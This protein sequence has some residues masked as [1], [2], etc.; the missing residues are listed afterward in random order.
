MQG[1]SGRLSVPRNSKSSPRIRRCRRKTLKTQNRTADSSV[2]RGAITPARRWIEAAAPYGDHV[3]AAARANPS[4]V[5]FEYA[6]APRV[7]GVA[8]HAGLVP[9][10]I[11]DVNRAF[12]RRAAARGGFF[13]ATFAVRRAGVSNDAPVFPP[14]ATNAIFLGSDG[15]FDGASFADDADA[16]G[17]W[18]HVGGAGAGVAPVAIRG[19]EFRPGGGF[20]GGGGSASSLV[21]R[22]EDVRGE[23]ARVEKDSGAREGAFADERGGRDAKGVEERSRIVAAH[24]VSSALV[25]AEPP[26]TPRLPLQRSSEARTVTVQHSTAALPWQGR[27]RMF[28]GVVQSPWRRPVL[29]KWRLRSDGARST[30]YSGQRVT[31]AD[32]Q[33]QPQPATHTT[34]ARSAVRAKR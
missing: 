17:A 11:V 30:I 24:F 18:W 27:I 10:R 28:P 29:V 20:G 19:A 14:D 12:E 23:S 31:E 25:V 32:P 22:F 6:P 26:A 16:G 33:R 5:E 8:L 1:P 15:D 3:S 21:A 7:H 13:T 2:A 4:S 9:G 34:R